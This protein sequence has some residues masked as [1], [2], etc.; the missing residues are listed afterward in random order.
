V[1]AALSR[2]PEATN[3]A[4]EE[5]VDAFAEQGYHAL[6]VSRTDQAGTWQLMG[7]IAL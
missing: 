5:R 7:L 3:A 2:E 1:I 6:A 4:L